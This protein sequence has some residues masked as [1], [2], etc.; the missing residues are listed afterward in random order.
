MVEITEFITDINLDQL[1]ITETWLNLEGDEGKIVD[2]APVGYTAKSFPRL[3]RCGGGI[4]V[5]YK[6]TIS[7]AITTI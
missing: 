4:A 2:L 7:A 5:V 1:F 6:N 3:S